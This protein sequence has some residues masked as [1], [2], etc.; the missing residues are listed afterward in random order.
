MKQSWYQ[1][2]L[3]ITTIAVLAIVVVIGALF[4]DVAKRTA[5]ERTQQMIIASLGEFLDTIENTAS[6]ACYVG[7]QPLAKELANGLLKN[8]SVL[9]VVIRTDQ[10]ELARS[11]R[12]PTSA[13]RAEK[14]A[15]GRLIRVIH[16]PFNPDDKVC[17]IQLDPDPDEIER[18]SNQKVAY[19]ARILGIQIAGTAATIFLAVRRATPV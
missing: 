4:I 12:T 2:I 19:L 9:G 14:S 1:S 18:Q 11:Y 13:Q 15:A 16:S 5:R 10:Q 17:E 8:S 7:D 3:F 6:I